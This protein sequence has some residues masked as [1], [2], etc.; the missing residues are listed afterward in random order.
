MMEN[1]TESI[2][3][4]SIGTLSVGI[5]IL[6]IAV[7]AMRSSR[8]SVKLAEE[9]SGYLSD[10]RERLKFLR[11]EYHTLQQ[12][13]E[14]ERQ[15]CLEAQRRA[16]YFER[17]YKRLEESYQESLQ[18][19]RKQLTQ[20]LLEFLKSGSMLGGDWEE[21]AGQFR[22]TESQPHE[23]HGSPDAQDLSEALPGE[24][25]HNTAS[26]RTLQEMPTNSQQEDT[27]TQK[28][29]EGGPTTVWRR[30]RRPI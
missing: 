14:Q 24:V 5:I 3:F 25:E 15:E 28:E 23:T 10:E 13:L 29:E 21:E 4:I 8:R 1:T 30:I 20:D 7:L 19:A 26:D 2:F 11:E 22:G 16:E 27:V 9:H 12:E 6:V 17:E 18:H